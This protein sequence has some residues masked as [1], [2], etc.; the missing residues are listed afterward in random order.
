[1]KIIFHIFIL[2]TFLLLSTISSEPVKS[3]NPTKAV[4]KKPKNPGLIEWVYKKGTK[5]QIT[6]HVN[7]KSSGDNLHR[8]SYEV[9]LIDKVEKNGR[10]KTFSKGSKYITYIMFNPSNA[11]HANL[12]A[13]V[14]RLIQITEQY[15]ETHRDVGS[16]KIRNLYEQRSPNPADVDVNN[17]EPITESMNTWG[18]GDR[19][20]VAFVKAW[21]SLRKNERQV[22]DRK[23]A[24]E[25]RL[26][27][28]KAPLAFLG[29][30]K[31]GAEKTYHPKAF[32]VARTPDSGRVPPIF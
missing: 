16:F 2:T 7:V 24:L 3:G 1:M 4:S 17:A 19:N 28:E 25:T 22:K 30:R 29:T 12:D 10:K 27:E 14:K 31:E 13:T 20:N 6:Y 9:K 15:A 8:S 21:G 32:S 23:Q 5:D 26:N 11:N 18:L